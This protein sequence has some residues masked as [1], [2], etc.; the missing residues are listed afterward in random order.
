MKKILV[1]MMDLLKYSHFLMGQR[2]K[3]LKKLKEKIKELKKEKESLID[4]I[5][6]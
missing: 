3:N 4:K 5:S 6:K 1:L 2:M